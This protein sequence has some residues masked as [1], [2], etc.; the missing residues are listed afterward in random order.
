VADSRRRPKPAVLLSE[1]VDGKQP[2]KPTRFDLK[3]V[4]PSAALSASLVPTSERDGHSASALLFVK[5]RFID[6][7]NI[8]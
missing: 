2:F 6:W 5:K 1:L 4:R 8:S 7:V 3:I